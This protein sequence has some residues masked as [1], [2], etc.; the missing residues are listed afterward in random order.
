[1]TKPLPTA[2]FKTIYPT[3]M[4]KNKAMSEIKDK[5]TVFEPGDKV[6]Y[7]ASHL[8]NQPLSKHDVE[9]GIVKRVTEAGVFVVYHCAQQWDNYEDYTAALT[10]P[11]NLKHGWL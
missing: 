2:T 7:I 6:H 9:N 11:E 4:L 1:M 5:S 10:E 3:G 8:R